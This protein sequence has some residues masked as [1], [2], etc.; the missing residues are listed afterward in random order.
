[1]GTH[2][3]VR[4]KF[5]GKF[6]AAKSFA[7]VNNKTAINTK[8]LRHQNFLKVYLL[9]SRNNYESSSYQRLC[10][11]GRARA[12]VLPLSLQ[13]PAKSLTKLSHSMCT[14]SSKHSQ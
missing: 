5:N 10:K 9:L 1:M 4:N 13:T 2:K 7:N 8:F 12:S 14:Q 3:S 11:R 6:T